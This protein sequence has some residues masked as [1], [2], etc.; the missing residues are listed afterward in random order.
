M[1][2]LQ[3]FWKAQKKKKQQ[4]KQKKKRKKKTWIFVS[5]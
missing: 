4:K 5:S 3:L 1:E 2:K